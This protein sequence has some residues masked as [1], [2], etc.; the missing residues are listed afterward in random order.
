MMRR[1]SRPD[2]NQ[3]EIV[4]ELRA[5]SAGVLH[6]HTIGGGAPDLVIGF[7]GANYLIELKSEAGRLANHQAVW[8]ATWPGQVA[9]CRTLEEVFEVIGLEVVE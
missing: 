1:R 8:H 7:R 2:L 9:V 6:I 4:E 3:A 5:I